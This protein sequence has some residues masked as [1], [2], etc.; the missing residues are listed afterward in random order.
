MKWFGLQR[1]HGRIPA[2][3]AC[4]SVDSSQ[5]HTHIS[6]NQFIKTF[7]LYYFIAQRHNIGYTATM[8]FIVPERKDAA[9][10]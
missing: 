5:E 7:L 8:V 6:N 2:Q 10:N 4:C 9:A 1:I 3:L